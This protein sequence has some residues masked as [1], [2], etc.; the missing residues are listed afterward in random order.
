MQ[1][2][3]FCNAKHLVPS[4]ITYKLRSIRIRHKR[5]LNGVRTRAEPDKEGKNKLK[6]SIHRQVDA[7]SAES[8]FAKELRR[9]GIDREPLNPTNKSFRRQGPS[10][11]GAFDDDRE[12]FDGP[13]IV[14]EDQLK[15]SRQL[16]SEGLEGLVPRVKELLTLGATSTFAFVPAIGVV[17]LVALSLYFVFGE[18]FVHLGNSVYTPPTYVDPYDLLG[19]PYT[20]Q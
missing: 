19:Y 2:L 14:T 5:K 20:D 9:R 3:M 15:R 18:S 16:N 7:E 1:T 12:V 8:L 6:N 11:E 4:T 17:I 10:L 13:P